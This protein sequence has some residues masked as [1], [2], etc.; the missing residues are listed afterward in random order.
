M[1][2]LLVIQVFVS[3]F[4]IGIY[5][6]SGLEPSP[7]FTFLDSATF[8]CGVVWWLNAEAR[9]SAAKQAYCLGLLVAIGWIIIVPYHLFKTR[10]A[11]G[12]IPLLA[13]LVSFLAAYLSAAFAYM[14]LSN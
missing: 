7:T 1:L 11:R 14:A 9:T 12:L 5:Q 13:L 3:H 6:L 2:V 4:G 10:G 8:L